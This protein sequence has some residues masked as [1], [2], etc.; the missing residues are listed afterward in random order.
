MS[1]FEHSL[2]FSSSLNH[3]CDMIVYSTVGSFLFHFCVS[4]LLVE[5]IFLH[6]VMMVVTFL[7]LLD[8]GLPKASFVK[9]SIGPEFPVFGYLG[10]SF[11]LFYLWRTAFVGSSTLSWNLGIY[12]LSRLGLHH[13]I[14]LW[15]PGFLLRNLLSIWW[16]CP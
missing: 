11:F 9:R 5:F 7:S 14:P 6:V 3:H 2:V 13:L 4:A 12:F 10:S 1:V 15:P 16:G 8:I